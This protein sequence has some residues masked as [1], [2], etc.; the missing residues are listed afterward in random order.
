M[1]NTGRDFYK[2]MEKKFIVKYVFFN[3]FVSK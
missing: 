1:N 3:S 2:I